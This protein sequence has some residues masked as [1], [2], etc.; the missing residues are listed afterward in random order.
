MFDYWYPP[1]LLVAKVGVV[2]GEKKDK[3]AD[4]DPVKLMT[5]FP[6]KIE[7][8]SFLSKKVEKWTLMH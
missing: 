6:K 1:S 4:F 5:G 8:T 2:T 7:N 3:N